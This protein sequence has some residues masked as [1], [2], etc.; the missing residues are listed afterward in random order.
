MKNDQI[1][2]RI[3]GLGLSENEARVYVSS[4][5]LGPSSALNIARHAGLKR[6]T[7]Y[8]IIDELI[9]R[10]CVRIEPKGF[11]RLF[12]AESPRTLENAL[13][14]RRKSFHDALPELEALYNQRESGAVIKY[15]EGTQAVKQVYESLLHEMKYGDT[16]LVIADVSQWLLLDEKFFQSFKE[17]RVKIG[18]ASRLLLVNNE[19]GR[20]T[21]SQARNFG[22]DVKLLPV[23][24]SMETSLIITS[25]QAIIHQYKPPTSLIVNQNKSSL[26]M[27]QEL[28][29]IIWNAQSPPLP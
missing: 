16:Y 6:S 28:F 9:K 29:E 8:S 27:Y 19:A 2:E 1:I 4:I 10:G 15:Y 18:L 22:D 13:E 5:S 14:Q 25:T 3:Q 11:K 26:Q 7:V 20:Q 17:R 24:R 21:A 12:A 23:G